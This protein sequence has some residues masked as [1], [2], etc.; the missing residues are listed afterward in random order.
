MNI[1]IHL[2]DEKELGDIHPQM[3]SLT[4]IGDKVEPFTVGATE[5]D[6][7]D[8]PLIFHTLRDKGL[9]PRDIMDHAIRLPTAQSGW[10]H[11][12]VVIAL[13]TRL[14][15]FRETATLVAMFVD[16]NAHGLESRQPQ[17]FTA[18][19]IAEM[20]V[21]M[22]ADE[23]SQGYA[24]GTA[25]G[26]IRDKRI[27]LSVMRIGEVLPPLDVKRHVEVAHALLQ[28]FH[29]LLLA[30]FPKEGVDLILMEDLPQPGEDALWEEAVFPAHFIL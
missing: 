30:V 24:V 27:E 11:Q 18:H 20:A 13:E 21:I 23:R 15:E 19:K 14:N 7:H 9:R 29:T 1:P 10:K 5:M 22:A 16:T 3:E 8:I 26:M 4:D 6:R 25:E 17:Q 28:P 12:H 2:V